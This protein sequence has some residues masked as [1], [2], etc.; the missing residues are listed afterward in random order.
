MLYEIGAQGL[1]PIE[2]ESKNNLSRGTILVLN[3]YD[4][5]RYVII[6]NLGVHDRFPDYGARYT[7]VSL[8]DYNQTQ[9]SAH[10]LKL[11]EE[12]K[13]G[14]IQTYILTE[15]MSEGDVLDIWEKSEETR[16]EKEA[17]QEVEAEV[18]AA[19]IARGKELFE[20]YIPKDAPA[21]IIAERV[22][23]TSDIQTDYFGHT[24]KD[25]II[26]GS[27]KHK[28]DLFSEM[29]KHAGKLPETEHLGKNIYDVKVVAKEPFTEN[30]RYHGKGFF[31]PWH[32]GLNKTFN[33][34]KEAQEYTKANEAHSI[35]F[36]EITALFEWDI[37]RREMEHRE[38]YSMGGGYYL[39]DGFRD[40]SGWSIS[41]A[42]KYR[43]WTDEF[44][45]SMGKR[46]IMEGAG[47]A[48]P[49]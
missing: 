47:T 33:S 43:G 31:S 35:T 32:T 1:K 15:M 19:H 27:S 48:H 5:P 34:E 12:K 30:G 25:L 2:T 4:N 46:C 17:A 42:L 11:I 29:R 14:R 3:G 24:Q 37:S 38:K 8:E 26:L 9:I 16:K 10:E 20:K 40:N 23:D 44:F 49:A 39:K 41:K 13:D 6:K 45:L 7:V 28:R 36:G 18:R 22:E 21:L